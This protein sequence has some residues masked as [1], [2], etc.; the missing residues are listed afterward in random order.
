MSALAILPFPSSSL[1]C[2]LPFYLI[3]AIALLVQYVV[4]P[5]LA[6][7]GKKLQARW[8]GALLAL[9]SACQQP[10]GAQ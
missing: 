7:C 2:S 3:Y 1:S 6:L 9:L 5:L 8:E 10:L 4:T